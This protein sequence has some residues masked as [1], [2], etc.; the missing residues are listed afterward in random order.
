MPV[1]RAPSALSDHTVRLIQP[2]APQ[3]QKWQ[4][5]MIPVFYDR[6]LALTA[7][8]P[9]AGGPRPD[10]VVWSETAIPWL[11]EVATPALEQIAEAAGGA[12]VIVGLQRRE[13]VQ[14]YNSL[15]VLD[16]TGDVAQL[17]DKHHIVPFGEYLPFGDLLSRFGLRGLAAADGNGYARGPGAQLLDLGPLG[18]GL[19]LICY[20][21]V[22]AHDVNAAPARPDMLIQIT[23]D[24]WFGIDG[25]PQQHLAQARMRAIEQGLPLMRAANTGISAMIDPR[26]RVTHRLGLGQAGFVDAPLPAPL[27]PTLYSRTGD[28]PL[29]VGLGLM[30]LIAGARARRNRQ[31]GSRR[32]RV[33]AGQPPR[34]MSRR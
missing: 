22:F 7:A 27:P 26:G 15:V 20:E 12:P 31:R 25:G 8:A 4:R 32:P 1:Q 17:Y 19:P 9:L 11:L 16:A 24:A 28:L 34:R 21:A 3:D 23:N 18:Q 33:A 14:L 13:D 6:Q 29:A 5:D 2:N 30:L 10:L